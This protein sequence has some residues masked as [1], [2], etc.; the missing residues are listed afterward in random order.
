[1]ATSVDSLGVNW[2]RMMDST[3]YP[4]A[5]LDR[6]LTLVYRNPASEIDDV[7]ASLEIG[8]AFPRSDDGAA[9]EHERVR[10]RSEFFET[11]LRQGGPLCFSE[12]MHLHGVDVIVFWVCL[13]VSS[14]SGDRLLVLGV[15]DAFRHPEHVEHP[16]TACATE[17]RIPLSVIAGEAESLSELMDEPGRSR[18]RIIMLTARRMLEQLETVSNAHQVVHGS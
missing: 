14:Q 5:V 6:D 17:F 7:F 12:T 3:R 2:T 10:A 9:T 16:D 15:S 18:A 4:M 8:R 1:M 11:C 13:K